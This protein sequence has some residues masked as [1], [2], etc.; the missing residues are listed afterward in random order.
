ME[1]L[2]AAVESHSVCERWAS[3]Q[4]LA[5]TGVAPA[6]VVAELIAQLMGSHDQQRRERA[7][8]LLARLSGKTVRSGRSLVPRRNAGGKTV[9]SGLHQGLHQ[10]DVLCSGPSWV[11]E[12]LQAL[13]LPIPPPPTST[14]NIM[15]FIPAS[16]AKKELHTE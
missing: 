7:A 10:L 14:T 2:L 6:P 4:C 12:C 16:N 1:V 5:V 9:R 8:E 15:S 13:S 11:V 3:V